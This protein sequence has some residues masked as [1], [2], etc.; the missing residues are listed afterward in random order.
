MGVALE[1]VIDLHMDAEGEMAKEQV[2]GET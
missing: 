2:Q 1:R